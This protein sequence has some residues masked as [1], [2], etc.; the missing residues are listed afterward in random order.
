MLCIVVHV[1]F[2]PSMPSRCEQGYVFKDFDRT[3]SKK[4]ILILNSLPIVFRALHGCAGT[5][6]GVMDLVLPVLKHIAGKRW[7]LRGILHTGSD[8]EVLASLGDY[9]LGK[10]H[11]HG[12]FGRTHNNMERLLAWLDERKLLEQQREEQ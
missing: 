12:L 1:I 9:G 2:S 6:K 5:G 8:T 3:L 7:R 11:V 10:D 4:N